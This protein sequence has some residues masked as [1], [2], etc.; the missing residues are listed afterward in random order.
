MSLNESSGFWDQAQ[1]VTSVLVNLSV[2]G[3]AIAAGI[4]FRILHLLSRRYRSDLCCHHHVL[5]DRRIVF[6]VEYAVQNT[7]ERPITFSQ[8]S[9]TLHP[10][11]REQALLLHDPN[12]VLAERV[13]VPD[14][15]SRGLFSVEA[16][17]RSIFTLRCE[18]PQ[19]PEIIFVLCKLSWPDRRAPAPFIGMYVPRDGTLSPKSAA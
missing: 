4:K 8:V 15:A 13:L 1:A 7:G 3:A 17:E 6:V 9:L 11:V 12:T 14:P 2:V 19:L 10:P 18:L 16:G 5:E